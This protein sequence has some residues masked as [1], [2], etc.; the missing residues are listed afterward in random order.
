MTES[1][2]SVRF[3]IQTKRKGM[4]I[5][6]GHSKA[7]T[8]A[9]WECL[10]KLVTG[11]RIFILQWILLLPYIVIYPEGIQMNNSFTFLKPTIPSIWTVYIVYIVTT[12]SYLSTYVRHCSGYWG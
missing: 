1:M 4:I 3:C 11:F 9:K 8:M 6:N 10:L 7:T 12:V 5:H 2:A